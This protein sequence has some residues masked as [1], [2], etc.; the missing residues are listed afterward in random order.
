M[1]G[2]GQPQWA[3]ACDDCEKMVTMETEDGVTS[4][5]CYLDVLSL[6][7]HLT[8]WRAGRI[9][10]CVMDGVCIGHP[11]CNVYHCTEPLRS[12]RDRYCPIHCALD[13]VC[14]ISGCEEPCTDGKRTCSD[15]THRGVEEERRKKGRT[16]FELK[17]RL[18]AHHM[19]SSIRALSSEDADTSEFEESDIDEPAI[20]S[21]VA[22]KEAKA[23][24]PKIKTTLTRRWTHNEQ[25]LVRPC[26]VIVSRCTFFEAESL[27]NERVSHLGLILPCE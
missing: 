1:V 20:T 24:Q 14:A 26:G 7:T 4:G 2:I 6:L 9:S 23:R 3:H 21:N 8:S 16:L 25:L 22:G 17:R 15:P 11:R 10:A 19:A 5:K 18:E 12:P 27:P 13:S